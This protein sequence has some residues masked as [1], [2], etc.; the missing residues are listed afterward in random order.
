MPP[1]C[2]DAEENTC[3][4]LDYTEH[5]HRIGSAASAPIKLLDERMP[6]RYRHKLN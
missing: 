2:V 1:D 5:T 3:K 4:Q 6:A